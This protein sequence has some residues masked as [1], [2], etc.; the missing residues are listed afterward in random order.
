MTKAAA[1]ILHLQALHQCVHRYAPRHDYLP[2]EMNAMTDDCS[3]L[4][5]LSDSQLLAHFYYLYPRPNSWRFFSL[6]PEMLSAVASAFSKMRSDPAS[7][8]HAPVQ[9]ID[10]GNV[11]SPFAMSTIS[12]RSY[13]TCQTRSQSSK[14]LQHAT[15]AEKLHPVVNLSDLV[16]W[17]TPYVRWARASPMWGPKTYEKTLPAM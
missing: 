4:W 15:E 5:D 8:L 9:P 6:K 13:L 16:R 2:G 17:T 11:G 1:Y 10:I 12:T 7:F 14:F 3:R